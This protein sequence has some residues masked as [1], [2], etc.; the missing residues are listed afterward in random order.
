M[1]DN[2]PRVRVANTA[3]ESIAR[4]AYGSFQ[5]L[6]DLA[7]T[8]SFEKPSVKLSYHAQERQN[9]LSLLCVCHASTD[10]DSL[11]HIRR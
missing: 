8:V 4:E 1:Y 9:D 2:T 11:E 5:N 6:Q 7:S 3:R 10:L